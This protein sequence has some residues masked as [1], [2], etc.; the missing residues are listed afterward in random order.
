MKKEQI[1]I[2][3]LTMCILGGCGA[4]KT[5]T[6]KKPSDDQIAISGYGAAET[7]ISYNSIA[8]LK[9]EAETIIYGEVK[10]YHYEIDN[11]SVYTIETVEVLESLYG[12]VEKG[13]SIQIFKVG[14]YVTLEDYINSFGD[15]SKEEVRNMVMFAN[16]TDEEIKEKYMKQF[17]DGEVDTDGGR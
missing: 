5:K 7:D 16:Y 15:E 2:I 1:G 8:Q 13:D 12:S 4:D 6:A 11:G 9:T 14:G 17:P 3:L 10:D